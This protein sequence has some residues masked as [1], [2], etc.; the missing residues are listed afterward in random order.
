LGIAESALTYVIDDRDRL[1]RLDS[2]FHL[3]A[4]A[5]AWPD[6]A[7]V[8]GRSLWDFVAGTAMRNLQRTLVRRIRN[9][10][11]SVELPFR[12]DGP[13][14]RREMVIAICPSQAGRLVEF[15]T[16]V[17]NEEARTFQPLLDPGAEHGEGEVVMCGWCDRFEVGGDWVEVEEAAARLKL[18]QRSESPTVS[19]G[20]CRRCSEMLA[21]A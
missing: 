19:H 4:G 2:G 5:N 3:F 7:A 14:R 21:S 13:S 9:E 6:S 20:V 18:F 17:R 8:L 10:T 11:R 15:K 12:C 1:I 16:R